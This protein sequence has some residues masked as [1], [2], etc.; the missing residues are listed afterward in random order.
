MSSENLAKLEALLQ[1]I[2]DMGTRTQADPDPA[3]AQTDPIKAAEQAQR[4]RCYLDGDPIGL[5]DAFSFILKL[6]QAQDAKGA[7]EGTD[8]TDAKPT[9]EM[10]L[11]EYRN[12]QVASPFERQE[13]ERRLQ[14]P[15]APKEAKRCSCRDHTQGMQP[16]RDPNCPIHGVVE[17]PE[18]GGGAT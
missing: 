5:A 3:P 17:L 15:P 18:G 16:W 14:V 13:I 1:Q 9:R 2:Y 11:A 10:T 7:P 12:W 6:T 8:M 4:M